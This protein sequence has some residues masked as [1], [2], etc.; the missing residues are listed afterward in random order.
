LFLIGKEGF[1]LTLSNDADFYSN[2][3]AGQKYMPEV[4]KVWYSQNLSGILKKYGS[5]TESLIKFDLLYRTLSDNFLVKVDRAS[6]LNALEVRCPFLDYRFLEFSNRI[7]TDYKVDMLRT[8]KIMREIISDRV[9][10][11][12]LNR[13][14]Q[15][16]MPPIIDWLYGD[17][18]NLVEEKLQGL[19]KRRILSGSQEAYLNKIASFK[20]RTEKETRIYG[21][22]L[23]TFWAL[24]LWAEKWL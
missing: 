12:I 22:K 3:L 24:G 23:Y 8:K 1:G 18:N 10:K 16:F 7:P 20:P 4:A 11:K 6:M 19:R 2:L 21:E 5:L 14:K 13:G 9:P 17:Y 15:G